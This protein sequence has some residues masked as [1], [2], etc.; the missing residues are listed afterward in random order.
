MRFNFDMDDSMKTNLLYRHWVNFK[1]RVKTEEYADVLFDNRWY[2]FSNFYKDLKDMFGSDKEGYVLDKDFLSNSRVY[3]KSTVCFIPQE[4]NNKVRSVRFK[5]LDELPI[6]VSRADSGFKFR[7]SLFGKRHE[8]YGFKN[9][10]EAFNKA[11]KVMESYYKA[12]SVVYKD[13]ISKDVYDA[14]R[15]YVLTPKG[16]DKPVINVNYTKLFRLN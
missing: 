3:C 6:Y 16:V 11:K 15:S 10:D 14:L 9:P 12:L 1:R 13:Q 5:K 4:L 7:V 8:E 2:R